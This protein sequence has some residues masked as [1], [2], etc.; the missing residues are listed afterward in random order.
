MVNFI[1]IAMGLLLTATIPLGIDYA[2]DKKL[3][4]KRLLPLL[5]RLAL[6]WLVASWAIYMGVAS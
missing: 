5:L 1:F 2:I 4:G 3:E 6:V